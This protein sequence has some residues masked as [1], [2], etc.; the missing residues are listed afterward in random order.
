MHMASLISHRHYSR[1]KA[2][3]WSQWKSHRNQG[4]ITPY[5]WRST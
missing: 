4:T 1:I 2:I 5:L 3:H